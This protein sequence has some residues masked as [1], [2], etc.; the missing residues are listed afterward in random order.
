MYRRGCPLILLRGH[1]FPKNL[2]ILCYLRHRRNLKPKQYR[3]RYFSKPYFL[4]L[5]Q[6][7]ICYFRPKQRPRQNKNQIRY[8]R[9]QP[10]YPSSFER[11][12]LLPRHYNCIRHFSH[13]PLKPYQNERRY[14]WERT[15]C[16]T[17]PEYCSPPLIK[18]SNKLVFNRISFTQNQT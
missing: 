4:F 13:K 12:R 1:Q 6:C 2:P 18:L 8:E 10:Y 15:E 5:L 9:S 7:L 16:W 11:P 3:V 14:K 17:Q